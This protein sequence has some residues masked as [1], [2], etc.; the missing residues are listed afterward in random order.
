MKLRQ[1]TIA[2]DSRRLVSALLALTLLLG[3]MPLTTGVVIVFGQSH[4]ELAMNFCHPLESATAAAPIALARPA[5]I[6]LA[7]ALVEVERLRYSARTLLTEFSLEPEN[8]PPESA[9]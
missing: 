6:P 1:S 8:P 9:A 3:S 2:L 4:P 5:L 7:P